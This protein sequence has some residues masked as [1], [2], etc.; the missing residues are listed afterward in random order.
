M[1]LYEPSALWKKPSDL[2]CSCVTNAHSEKCPERW[3]HFLDTYHRFKFVTVSDVKRKKA[4]KSQTGSS[5][6]SLDSM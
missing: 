6:T 2:R 4:I 3:C 1:C 5:R